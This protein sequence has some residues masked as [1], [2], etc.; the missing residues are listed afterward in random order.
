VTESRISIS[1]ASILFAFTFLVQYSG[2]I[3]A[4]FLLTSIACTAYAIHRHRKTDWK[5]SIICGYLINATYLALVSLIALP[6]LKNFAGFPFEVLFREPIQTSFKMSDSLSVSRDSRELSRLGSL[7]IIGLPGLLFLFSSRRRISSNLFNE[8]LRTNFVLSAPFLL[9]L[10]YSTVKLLKPWNLLAPIMSGDGRNNFLLTMAARSSALEPLTFI[11]VGI[12]PNSL[13]SFL[14]A[15]NGSSGVSDVKDLWAM[16]FVW[17]ISTAL[18]A[19]ALN[20]TITLALGLKESEKISLLVIGLVTILFATNPAILSFCLNDGFFSLYCAVAILSGGISI[21]IVRQSGIEL[22]VLIFVVSIG[23]TFSYILLLPAFLAF[24]I[25]F[26]YQIVKNYENNFRWRQLQVCISIGVLVCLGVFGGDIWKIYLSSVTL[27]GAFIPMAPTM[28]ACLTTFQ[29]VI[30]KFA[31]EELVRCWQG[32]SLFGLAS[33]IQYTVIEIANSSFFDTNN[34]YYGTK[35]IVAATF[36]SAGFSIPLLFSTTL[37]ARLLMKRLAVSALICAMCLSYYG[38]SSQTRLPSPIPM[39]LKGW[40]YPD[41][42]EAELVVAY[43]PIRNMMFIEFSKF[44]SNAD[45]TWRAETQAANDRILNFW[46]PAFWNVDEKSNV[47]LY[48]WIY[49]NWDP[50]N[51]TSLCPLFESDI[52]VVVTRSK[53]LES[54]LRSACVRL[55][56]FR[57]VKN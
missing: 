10:S 22:V 1:N 2:G 8:K 3:G 30:S 4:T 29:F 9:V 48:N 19:I 56:K 46:S 16:S 24:F 44:P 6:I 27:A 39:I 55:P 18:I 47:G 38:L 26:A 33:L 53:S 21:A 49:N 57:L 50:N 11:D 15:A 40:G 17:L 5:V 35:I 14:S 23:L 13:A 43:W 36:I 25:P 54:R 32:L 45:G 28:L 31:K 41:S 7:L 34:S 12:L 37:G 51:L 42:S 20:H 52:D